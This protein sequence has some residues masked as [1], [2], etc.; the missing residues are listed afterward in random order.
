MPGVD[1]RQAYGR[2]YSL[3]V[4]HKPDARKISIAQRIGES[5]KTSGGEPTAILGQLDRHVTD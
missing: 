3:R 2:G 1:G 5:T 4:R